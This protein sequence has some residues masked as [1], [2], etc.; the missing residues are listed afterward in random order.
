MADN[1]RGFL[2]CGFPA[3]SKRGKV[4]VH[5]V[6]VHEAMPHFRKPLLCSV[7]FILESFFL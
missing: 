1:G 4:D 6:S 3:L 2:L 5:C 7:K